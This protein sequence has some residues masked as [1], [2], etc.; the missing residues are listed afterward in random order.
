MA[1]DLG[2]ENVLGDVDSLKDA[3]SNLE[4][5][6]KFIVNWYKATEKADNKE[7]WWKRI[8]AVRATVEEAWHANDPADVFPGK[9]AKTTYAAAQLAFPQ[10]WRDISFTPDRI[11]VSLAATMADTFNAIVY[12][13]GIWFKKTAQDVLGGLGINTLWPI[14]IVAGVV[15]LAYFYFTRRGK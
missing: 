13:P 15:L 6:L 5:A 11:D 10:M 2:P 7:D 4:R 12:F 14:I 3:R 1:A 9:T 8:D